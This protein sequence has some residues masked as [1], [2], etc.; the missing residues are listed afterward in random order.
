MTT[1]TVTNSN[2]SGVG[3]LRWAVAQ[4]NDNAGLDTIEFGVELVTLTSAISINDSVDINGDD[5]TIKQTGNYR[6]FNINDNSDKLIDVSLNSV[7]LIGGRPEEFGGAIL[8]LENLT[9]DESVVRDNV[10]TEHGGGIY[11][12]GGSLTITNS[13]FEGNKIS[14]DNQTYSGG[15]IFAINGNVNIDRST[16]EN[17]DSAIHSIAVDNSLL[18]ISNSSIQNNFGGGIFVTTNSVAEINNTGI[19][20]NTNETSGAG[21]RVEDN[22]KATISDSIING[23][24]SNYGAGIFID[25]AEA[26]I[27]NSGIINN[28][29]NEAGG[30]INIVGANAQLTIQSSNVFGNIAPIGSALETDDYGTAFIVN[31]TIK[32][33]TGSQNQ[34]DGENITF[35]GGNTGGILDP[36]P[37]VEEPVIEE[38]VVEDPV[39]EEPVVEEPVVEEPVVEEP[40]VEEP[41]FDLVSVE[42]FYQTE[43]GFHFYTADA[44]ESQ[45]IKTQSEAG[46]LSYSYE[47]A[48]FSGLA[49]NTDS[50]TG[51]LIEGAEEVYR[52]YNNQTG[53]HLYTMDENEKSYIQENL[54][55]YSF[56]GTAYYAFESEQLGLE[57]IPVYRM[58]NGDTGTH[59][60]SADQN[61]IGYIQDNLNNYSLEG[62]NGIAFY[63]LEF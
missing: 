50:L 6:L 57:T 46:E 33:N 28:T 18:K 45:S 32:D 58:L 2:D 36:N 35:G 62:E 60:F 55:N 14:L 63:V 20:N 17:N 52:F 56:E 38:P 49:S 5:V 40:V 59:L 7:T 26:E 41:S 1:Y 10:T 21:I 4:A 30:G 29:A 31:A 61:E 16:F 42:R 54:D 22:A 34:L 23:N 8:S 39:V 24:Q 27:I 53:A 12:K 25:K 44:N 47:N 11:S 37:V 43:T 48:A 9:V 13:L 51:D 19:A 15:A 3:S